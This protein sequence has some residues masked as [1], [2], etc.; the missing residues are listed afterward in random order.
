MQKGQEETWIYTRD[1]AD[2]LTKKLHELY[3][4]LPS[5]ERVI[6]RDMLSRGANCVA[7]QRAFKSLIGDQELGSDA[8]R[9]SLCVTW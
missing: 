8:I 5:G 2:S 9:E 3:G 7:R 1:Q 6:M 4:S